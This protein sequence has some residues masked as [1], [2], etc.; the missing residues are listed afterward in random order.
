MPV[1]L[2][3]ESLEEA[4]GGAGASPA[5][6]AEV[7]HAVLAALDGF[8]AEDAAAPVD[9]LLEIPHGVIRVV[10]H[11]HDGAHRIGIR[12]HIHKIMCESECINSV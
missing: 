12:P 4:R 9:A 3:H 6:L 1:A 7:A 10:E 11:R 8:E 2:L 5:T